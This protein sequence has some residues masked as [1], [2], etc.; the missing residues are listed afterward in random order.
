MTPNQPGVY[1]VEGKRRTA[2]QNDRVA[3]RTVVEVRKYQWGAR[4]GLAV[5]FFGRQNPYRLDA[6][7]A[8]WELLPLQFDGGMAQ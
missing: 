4:W 8:D 5:F 1:R 3:V 2:R 7:E 6:F